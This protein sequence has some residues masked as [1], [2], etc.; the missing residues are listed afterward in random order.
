[1]TQ[2]SYEGLANVL[3]DAIVD[4]ILSAISL[5]SR[6]LLSPSETRIAED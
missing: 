1:M 4:Q 2:N 3:N 6:A 5:F